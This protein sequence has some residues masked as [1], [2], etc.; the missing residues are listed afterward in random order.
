MGR[1]GWE[2][3]AKRIRLLLLDADG[4]LTD[5]RIAYDGAGREIKFFDVKDGQGIQLLH[6]AGL[7]VGI[8]SGRGSP[9]VRIRAKE[10][11]IILLRQRVRDKAKALEEIMSKNSY[12]PEQICFVGD[13][14]VDLPVFARVGL[15]VAVADGTEDVKAEAHYITHHSGGKGAVR[16]VCDLILK[17]QGKWEA[18]TQKYF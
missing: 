18:V 14:L 16:E 12:T 3:R 11:G 17:A 6:R 1:N 2:K 13:D 10:L 5:G 8:L 9:A 15:A 4:V 7:E